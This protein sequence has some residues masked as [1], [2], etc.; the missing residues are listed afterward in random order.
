MPEVKTNTDL[1]L[2]QIDKWIESSKQQAEVF[3][4]LSMDTSATSS[5]AMAQAYWNVKQFIEVNFNK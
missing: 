2:L 3:T 4:L 1:I 5:T